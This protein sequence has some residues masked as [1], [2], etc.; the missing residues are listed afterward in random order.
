MEIKQNSMKNN[1]N[2]EIKLSQIKLYYINNIQ[3]KNK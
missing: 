2:R 3:L 1:V